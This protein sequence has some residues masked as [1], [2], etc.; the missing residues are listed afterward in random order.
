VLAVGA[1]VQSRQQTL[2]A[3]DLL[4][5]GCVC[6]SVSRVCVCGLHPHR[7]AHLPHGRHGS[8]QQRRREQRWLVARRTVSPFPPTARL[9]PL[10]S[11]RLQ[12]RI[13][14]FH[15][16]LARLSQLPPTTNQHPPASSGAFRPAMTHAFHDKIIREER[17]R[18]SWERTFGNMDSIPKQR[19]VSS[20][21]QI[22]RLAGWV[23]V[24]HSGGS[25]WPLAWCSL[26]G[27]I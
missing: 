18:R 17:V 20:T 25:H 27:Q 21:K 1:K 9:S 6:L 19:R 16:T 13:E 10:L 11:Q 7:S 26:R 2:V 24:V 14:P 22:H 8:Q 15:R 3:V 12:G 23:V 5:C 4:R